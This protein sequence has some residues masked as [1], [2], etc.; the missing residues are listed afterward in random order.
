M[1]TPHLITVDE[2]ASTEIVAAG[3]KLSVQVAGQSFFTGGEAFKKAAEVANLVAGLQQVGIAEDD[4][5]L[6][7]VST[8]VETG[9]LSKASSATYRIQ[10]N[11]PDVD[12]LGR[13]VSVIS[14]Q[15]NAKVVALSWEYPD[16]D[17]TRRRVIHEAV[18]AAKDTATNITRALGVPLLG[19]HKMSY[20]VTGLDTDVHMP[21][22]LGAFTK[23]KKAMRER[24]ALE[25]LS[26]AHTAKVTA[27]VTAEFV[28]G[29]FGEGG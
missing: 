28:V 12:L 19:V 11:C 5:R 4:I 23:H 14:S 17:A 10:V 15:K 7:D 26:L 27:G 9:L 25:T 8:E 24:S 22:A 13:V 20:A 2:S 1:T 18:S 29:R 21:A 3:A 6:I 16:L